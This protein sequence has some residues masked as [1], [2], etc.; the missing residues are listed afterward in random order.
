MHE[1]QTSFRDNLLQRAEKLRQT[2]EDF[3]TNGKEFS[4][5]KK[6]YQEFKEVCP[7]WTASIAGPNLLKC[8]NATNRARFSWHTFYL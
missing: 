8:E 6:I 4:E 1:P 5:V 2:M 7:N 3:M